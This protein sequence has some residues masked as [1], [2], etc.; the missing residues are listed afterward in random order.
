MLD[1]AL[2]DRSDDYM[3]NKGIPMR[4]ELFDPNEKEGKIK[5][6]TR[7]TKDGEYNPY[8]DVDVDIHTVHE[9][10]Q[11]LMKYYVEDIIARLV[12]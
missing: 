10:F 3:T 8:I 9:A 7:R 6:T 5:P 12:H 4:M 2:K 1:N 11:F